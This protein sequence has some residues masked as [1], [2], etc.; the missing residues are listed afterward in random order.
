MNREALK[1][2]IG[3]LLIKKGFCSWISRSMLWVFRK[4]KRSKLY[5]GC[6]LNKIS[7][8]R[9]S[10][11]CTRRSKTSWKFRNKIV[12]FRKHSSKWRK[13]STMPVHKSKSRSKNVLVKC[14]RAMRKRRKGSISSLAVKAKMQMRDALRKTWTYLEPRQERL[15]SLVW[16]LMRP[17]VH[18]KTRR[19]WFRD[20]VR[21][22][23]IFSMN[24]RTN[25]IQTLN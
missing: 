22:T 4:T 13:I 5:T 10:A 6:N 3:L 17:F 23:L 2:Q 18:A 21:M 20:W 19:H 8:R 16:R 14:K 1:N 9:L 12:K 15:K 25:S 11:M 24:Y 7:I